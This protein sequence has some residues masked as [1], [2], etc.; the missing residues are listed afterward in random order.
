MEPR[1]DDMLMKLKEIIQFVGS[2]FHGFEMDF[3]AYD[4]RTFHI[5]VEKK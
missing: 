5:K 1:I 4:G 3:E 2:K